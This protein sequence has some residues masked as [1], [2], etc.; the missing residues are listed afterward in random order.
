[1]AK[2]FLVPI[3]MNGL[4]IQNFL[5]HNLGSVPT[6][7]AGKLYFNTTD[8]KLYYHNGTDWVDLTASTN[9]TYTLTQ[10]GSTITLTGSDGTTM[11]VSGEVNQN[12]FSNVKVGTTTLAADSKTDTLNLTA[13][14]NITLTPD[15]STD[16][17]TI[18]ATDT[19]YSDAT[20]SASGL[21]SSTD[22]TKLNGIATGAEVNVNADWDATSGDAQI[23]NKPT[24]G[25]AAAKGVDTSIS[26]G[27]TSTNL[28]TSSA[29]AAFISSEIGVVDAM[30]FKGTIG[31]GGTVTTL[32]TSGVKVGDTYRV[33]T[34][35]T[36]AGQT[37]EV[38]DLII[39]TA[40]TPTWT[41]AQTNIDGAITSISGTAPI[42]VTGSG[43]S[44]TVSISNA[45]TSASGAMSSEDKTK[46]DGIESGAEANRTYTAFTGKPTAN[47]TPSFG[48]TFT[49]SQIK[50]DADGQITGTDRT[51]KI[52][53]TTATTS[54]AGLMSASDKTKLNGLANLK[55]WEGS[56]VP[57]QT[58][59]TSSLSTSGPTIVNVYA[60]TPPGEEV[61]IDMSDLG[62]YFKFKIAQAAL[63]YINVCVLYIDQ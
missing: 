23:L 22:K 44:R 40:T 6:G 52:P 9:T 1:M 51:V 55:V 26:S 29:V 2:S 42:S 61:I 53:N 60:T 33:I 3:N 63:E 15:S 19:T 46:L 12:A 11:T 10:S 5:V 34:A 37:C 38:G 36:Y 17:V 35:G 58:E 27:S 57:G 13:G 48:S 8:H 43:S 54:I 24:L 28:P 62:S 49:I 47:Q 32:P 21:M 14:S 7:T 59:V 25:A 18:N 16:T 56:I 20:T 45:T 50:Q 4:E 31:T 41:V 30:R 39:A